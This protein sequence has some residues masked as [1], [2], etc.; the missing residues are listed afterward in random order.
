MVRKMSYISFV[1]VKKEYRMGEVTIKAVDGV[2]F[3][4]EKGEFAM[5]QPGAGSSKIS[6]TMPYKASSTMPV[7]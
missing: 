6:T 7:S 3:V 4:I 2:D 1:D 5:Y